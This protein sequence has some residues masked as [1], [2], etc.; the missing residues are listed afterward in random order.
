MKSDIRWVTPTYTLTHPCSHD[1][2]TLPF[3][4][5]A[6]H[7]MEHSDRRVRAGPMVRWVNLRATV[8]FIARRFTT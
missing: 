4:M 5:G 2:S 7:Q 6:T 1:C 3:K 8:W